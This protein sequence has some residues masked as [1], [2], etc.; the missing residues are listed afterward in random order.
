MQTLG[1]PNKSTRSKGQYRFRTIKELLKIEKD[2]NTLIVN[3]VKKYIPKDKEIQ[4]TKHFGKDQGAA[5]DI[6]SN[7]KHHLK[8]DGKKLRL[9]IKANIIFIT[10]TLN[11]HLI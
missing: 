11:T 9:V 6:W 1:Y 5:F 4:Q 3:L 8:G 2:L 10:M 7:M